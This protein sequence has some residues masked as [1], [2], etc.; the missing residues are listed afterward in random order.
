MKKSIGIITAAAILICICSAAQAC[1]TGQREYI[2]VFEPGITW[3]KAAAEVSSWGGSYHLATVTTGGEQKRLEKLLSGLRGEFWI[4]G[5]Q[6]S[7][8]KWNWVTGEPWRYNRWAPGEPD[9]FGRGSEYLAISS[10]YNKCSWNLPGMG[11]RYSH[12]GS[13]GWFHDARFMARGR[14][15][16]FSLEWNDEGNPR[17]ISGFIAEKEIQDHNQPPAVPIPP[18]IWLFASGIGVLAGVR[19]LWKR[20][21]R[22]PPGMANPQPR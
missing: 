18:S 22:I 5:Y 14:Q 4:G 8:D 7:N 1:L 12:W 3:E 21:N 2:V 9:D 19:R 15:H 11:R 16:D 17:R 10:I 20:K 13:E 6:D